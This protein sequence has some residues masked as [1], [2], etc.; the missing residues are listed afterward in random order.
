[1]KAVDEMECEAGILAQSRHYRM[2]GSAESTG[3]DMI[4]SCH[5]GDMHFIFWTGP[6][7]LILWSPTGASQPTGTPVVQSIAIMVLCA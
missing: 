5:S 4:T 7:D 2:N 3:E 1:M 6:R